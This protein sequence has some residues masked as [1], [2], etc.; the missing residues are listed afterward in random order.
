[1]KYIFSGIVGGLIGSL[2]VFTTI[3]LEWPVWAGYL[4]AISIMVLLFAWKYTK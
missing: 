1:V 3:Y 4:L 2:S